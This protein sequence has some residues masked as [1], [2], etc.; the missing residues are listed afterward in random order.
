MSLT[1][2]NKRE[3]KV[4]IVKGCELERIEYF[5]LGAVY[6]WNNNCKTDKGEPRKFAARDLVGGV[7]KDWEGTPL[8][9]LSREH[10]GKAR[11]SK[12]TAEQEA[13]KDLGWILYTV[14]KEDKR[15]HFKKCPGHVAEYLWDGTTEEMKKK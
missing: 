7:N 4:T 3:K 13:G 8:L 5:L 14:L 11:A 6:C 12:K 9:V 15:R 2:L 10:K 1:P